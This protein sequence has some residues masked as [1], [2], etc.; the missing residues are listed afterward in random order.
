VVTALKRVDEA[1]LALN[2]FERTLMDKKIDLNRHLSD[3]IAETPFWQPFEQHRLR[4]IQKRFHEFSDSIYCACDD[5][6]ALVRCHKQTQDMGIAI[7]ESTKAK[8]ELSIALLNAPSL[9]CAIELLRSRLA[10]HKA[11]L[12]S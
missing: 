11:A 5:I 10:E 2:Q 1:D 3:V 7:V 9:R 12:G 6:A 8:H 4:Q